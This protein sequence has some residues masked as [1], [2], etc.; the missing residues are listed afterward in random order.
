MLLLLQPA[1]GAEAHIL[2]GLKHLGFTYATRSGLSIG[3]DDLIIPQEKTSL[4]DKARDEVIK[5][6]DKDATRRAAQAAGD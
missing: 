5:G 4:V 3:I 6:S 2:D 1:K